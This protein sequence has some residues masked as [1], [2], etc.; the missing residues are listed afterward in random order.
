MS[1][2]QLLP[3][4]PSSGL[5]SFQSKIFFFF[6]YSIFSLFTFQCYPLSRSPLWKPPI[7]PSPPPLCGCSHTHPHPPS[8]P[9]I[10]YTGASYPRRTKGCS[11]HPLVEHIRQTQ[12]LLTYLLLWNPGEPPCEVKHHKDLVQKQW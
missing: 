8:F 4:V 2:R 12:A 1:T 11:S 5:C 9:G 6:F 10:P 7:P 3:I